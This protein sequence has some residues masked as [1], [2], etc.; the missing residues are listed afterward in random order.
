MR[1]HGEVSQIEMG[2][3]ARVA[4]GGRGEGERVLGEGRKGVPAV[5]PVDPGGCGAGAGDCGIGEV[6]G[7]VGGGEG[8]EGG[9]ELGV[10]WFREGNWIGEV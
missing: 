2:A 3:R 4:P 7:G 10:G 9:G 8:E 6:G 5:A 1:A